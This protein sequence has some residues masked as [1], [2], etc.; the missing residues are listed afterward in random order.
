[1]EKNSDSTSYNFL[2]E[3]QQRLDLWSFVMGQWQQLIKAQ[4]KISVYGN[5][6]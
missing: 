5:S 3:E 4:N 6:E 1:M 2:L